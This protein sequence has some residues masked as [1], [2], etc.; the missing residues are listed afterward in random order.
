MRNG[1]TI[2]IEKTPAPIIAI[3]VNLQI[4]ICLI[5]Q[6]YYFTTALHTIPLNILNLLLPYYLQPSSALPVPAVLRLVSSACGSFAPTIGAV[7]PK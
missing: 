1:N 4:L 7:I 3:I 5:V 2:T 6:R